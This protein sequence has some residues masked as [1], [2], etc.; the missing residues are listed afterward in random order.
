MPLYPS[1]RTIVLDRAAH[2]TLSLCADLPDRRDSPVGT[3]VGLSITMAHS[4]PMDNSAWSPCFLTVIEGGLQQEGLA[5]RIATGCG[6]PEA[7][8]M[9]YAQLV[10]DGLDALEYDFLSDIMNSSSPHDGIDMRHVIFTRHGAAILDTVHAPAESDLD[11]A[12]HEM[13]G[14]SALLS[15]E[16]PTAH[17]RIAQQADLQRLYEDAQALLERHLFQTQRAHVQP[18]P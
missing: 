18:Y 17:G 15:I 11:M 12:R 5:S 4:S 2:R 9:A 16:P 3:I 8:L 7:A 6:A 1:L 10:E 14:R 13:G